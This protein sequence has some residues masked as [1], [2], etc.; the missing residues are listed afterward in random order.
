MIALYCVPVVENQ[1]LLPPMDGEGLHLAHAEGDGY[2]IKSGARQDTVI[3]A[4]CTDEATHNA[5]KLNPDLL[6]LED[7]PDA[8]A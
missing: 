2:S 1:L 7:I 6:W 3:C 5:L 4:V 8:E